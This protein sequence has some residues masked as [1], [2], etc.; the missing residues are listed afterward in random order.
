MP[1]LEPSSD[2]TRVFKPLSDDDYLQKRRCYKCKTIMEPLR[3]NHENIAVPWK[4]KGIDFQCTSC[5]EVVFIIDR[6]SVI[7][8][9][10]AAVVI[11]FVVVY[12]L[13]SGLLDFI[14]S[15]FQDSFG[16]V[17]LAIGI[18][19]IIA[20]F[21]YGIWLNL[22]SISQLIEQ[23]NRYPQIDLKPAARK[24]GHALALG[25]LPWMAVIGFGYLN[26]QFSIV[27]GS[28]LY[29]GIPLVL[30]PLLLASRFN[31]TPFKGFLGSLFWFVLA[32]VIYLMVRS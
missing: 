4:E 5:D 1:T 17:L 31:T 7:T 15:S 8:S 20:V 3:R 23:K 19:V 6:N 25:I 30:S 22:K 29:L 9:I 21:I 14:I 11:G 26:N 13:V 27:S 2:K 10:V 32:F 28:A 16:G 24:Q 12:F 18:C